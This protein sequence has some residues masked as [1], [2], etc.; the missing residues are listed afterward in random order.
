[1][2]DI[3]G[4]YKAEIEYIAKHMSGD[5][6]ILDLSKFG[7][8]NLDDYFLDKQDYQLKLESASIHF[9]S[10]NEIDKITESAILNKNPSVWIPQSNS[11]F[12]WYG[13]EPINNALI[14]EKEIDVYN[15]GYIGGTIVSG[16]E[17]LSVEIIVPD[18][19]Y[20][21]Q[22]FL[23]RLCKLIPDSYCDNN[24]IMQGGKKVVGAMSRTINGMFVF[25]FNAT[26]ADRQDLINEICLV[27][28][29]KQVGFITGINKNILLQEVL[30]WL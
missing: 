18:K 2:R 19:G 10:M 14:K 29:D 30:K 4:A 22:H 6:V 17:D 7:Y 11:T 24:D 23:E 15:M 8:T 5:A 28:K 21:F 12:L 13:G 1:M 25:A 27:S 16:A 26:F 3:A 20:D 9:T